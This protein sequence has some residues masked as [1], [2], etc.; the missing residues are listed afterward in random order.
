M[1][2]LPLRVCSVCICEGSKVPKSKR[3]TLRYECLGLPKVSLAK[4]MKFL[5]SYLIISTLYYKMNLRFNGSDALHEF[6]CVHSVYGVKGPCVSSV[7]STTEMWNLLS[8][9]FARPKSMV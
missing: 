8:L 1:T 5:S 2:L 4:R 3:R 6:V 9:L 7:P